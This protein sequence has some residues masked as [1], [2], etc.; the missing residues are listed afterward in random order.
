M[1]GEVF[2]V[3]W[4]GGRRTADKKRRKTFILGSPVFFNL[5]ITTKIKIGVKLYSKD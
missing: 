1:S 2:M 4:M 5:L 3:G